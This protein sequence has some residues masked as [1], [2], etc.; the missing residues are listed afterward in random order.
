[1]RISKKADYALRAMLAMARRGLVRPIQV[2]ELAESERIPLKFLEQILLALKRA[3][4]LVS[5]RG[6]GGGYLL[7]KSPEKI[8]LLDILETIDGP[9]L[10]AS[11]CD[12][13]PRV[14]RCG[15]G[16]PLPCGIGQAWQELRL[17]VMTHLGEQSLA[18]VLTREQPTSVAFD[19]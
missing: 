7:A 19:I 8:S 11:C 10:P 18:H 9:F 13:P 15:C 4:L 17:N 3:G 5:K 14:G 12:A 2:Q 1:M 16:G 6:A